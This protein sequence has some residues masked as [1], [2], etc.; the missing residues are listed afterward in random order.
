MKYLQVEAHVRP[1]NDTTA[2]VNAWLASLGLNA[3]VLSSA[4]DW[5]GVNVSVSQANSMFGTE[6]QYFTHNDTGK[7]HIRTMQYSIPESLQGHLDLVH[8]TV[9]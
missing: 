8:P 2:K 6:F 9:T 7:Q 3:T 1:S 4:G 5:L